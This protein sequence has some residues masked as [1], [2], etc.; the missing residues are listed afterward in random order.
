[1]T[2]YK[3]NSLTNYF[4]GKIM[5]LRGPKPKDGNTKN[6]IIGTRVSEVDYQK[7]L[8]ICLDENKNVSEKLLNSIYQVI[9]QEQKTEQN[10]ERWLER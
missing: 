7:F 1:M 4:Q 9:G 3:N 5:G 8:K 2:V 10:G 6:R